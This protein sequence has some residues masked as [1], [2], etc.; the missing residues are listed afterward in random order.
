MLDEARPALFVDPG[1]QIHRDVAHLPVEVAL[2]IVEV[3]QLD[4][5]QVADRP[6]VADVLPERPERIA[7]ALQPFAE[8]GHDVVGG[9]FDRRPTGPGVSFRAAYQASLALT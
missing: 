4:V 7:V 3:N 2:Q 9:A 5:R 8:I 6:P 1:A